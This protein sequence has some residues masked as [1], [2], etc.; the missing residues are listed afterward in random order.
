MT[1]VMAGMIERGVGSMGGGYESARER[2]K[3]NR[4][5]RAKRRVT[6]INNGREKARRRVQSK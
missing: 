1:G 4:T 2:E 3:E 6:H 5:D